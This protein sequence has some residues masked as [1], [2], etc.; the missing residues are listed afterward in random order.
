VYSI[1]RFQLKDK[2]QG[3]LIV[4]DHVGFPNGQGSHL[5]GGWYANYWNPL[6]R[7]LS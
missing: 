6:R 3:T 7:V 1:A 4:F 5:A 2:G